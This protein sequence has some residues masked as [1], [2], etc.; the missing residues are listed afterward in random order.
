M[1]SV[2]RDAINKHP[3]MAPEQPEPNEG[4]DESVASSLSSLTT[5][6]HA[7][8]WDENQPESHHNQKFNW[9]EGTARKTQTFKRIDERN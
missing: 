4:D 1:A 6:P 3:I 5:P 8:N 9:E 2:I 7:W